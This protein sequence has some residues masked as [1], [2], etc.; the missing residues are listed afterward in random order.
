MKDAQWHWLSREGRRGK[1]GLKGRGW[2]TGNRKHDAKIMSWYQNGRTSNKPTCNPPS[3]KPTQPRSLS[4]CTEATT[5][6]HAKPKPTTTPATT[7][8]T[9]LFP[10][11]FGRRKRQEKLLCTLHT[12]S[13]AMACHISSCKCYSASSYTGEFLSHQYFSGI[14]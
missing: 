10:F 13:R 3:S 11:R 2:M 4:T 5:T 8:T 12:C 7:T 6:L 1:G 9:T 14:S